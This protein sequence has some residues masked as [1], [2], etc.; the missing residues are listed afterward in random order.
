MRQNCKRVYTEDD[1]LFPILLLRQAWS[2][3]LQNIGGGFFGAA[4]TV[5]FIYTDC[6]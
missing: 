1:S 4:L 5:L 3:F 6:L 2:S